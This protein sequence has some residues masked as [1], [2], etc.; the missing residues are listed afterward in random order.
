MSAGL[1]SLLIEYQ[2]IFLVNVARLIL[3]AAGLGYYVAGG[4]L[5]RSYFEAQRLAALNLGSPLS[6]HCERLAFDLILRRDVD[7][8]GDQDWLKHSNEY[9]QLGQYWKGLH[10]L[11]RWGGDFLPPRVDGNHFSMSYLGRK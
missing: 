4:E 10:H 3:H 1:N 9:A 7:D 8:D 2:N 11:N 6:L 5:Y